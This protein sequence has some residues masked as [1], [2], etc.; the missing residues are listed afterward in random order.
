MGVYVSK[1]NPVSAQ[2]RIPEKLKDKKPLPNVRFK[3][4]D[5]ALREALRL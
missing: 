5:P 1:H 4:N 2:S 3:V